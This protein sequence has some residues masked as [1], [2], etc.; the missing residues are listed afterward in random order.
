MC[1]FVGI[2]G[3]DGIGMQ[4]ASIIYGANLFCSS[5]KCFFTRAERMASNKLFGS[6][7]WRN[8]VSSFA[9]RYLWRR[10]EMK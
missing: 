4:R 5:L 8:S 7:G 2:G 3:D 10:A 6:G 9:L 1:V